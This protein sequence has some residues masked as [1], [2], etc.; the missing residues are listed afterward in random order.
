MKSGH[1]AII[2]A[3]ADLL[4][5]D[6]RRFFFSFWVSLY[7]VVFHATRRNLI[8]CVESPGLLLVR[9]RVFS[10]L[11]SGVSFVFLR[12]TFSSPMVPPTIQFAYR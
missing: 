1:P 8:C 6:V 11:P 2:M 3:W 5:R 10:S 9:E 7:F 4:N 12:P